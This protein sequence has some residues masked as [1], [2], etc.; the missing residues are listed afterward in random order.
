MTPSLSNI[1]IQDR[2]IWITGTSRG[3]GKVLA[4]QFIN[5]G[6]IV[7]ATCRSGKQEELESLIAEKGSKSTVLPQDVTK[8][9]DAENISKYIRS[10]YGRLDVLINNAA[11]DP[12]VPAE[13]MNFKDWHE[14]INTNLDGSWLCCQYAIPLMKK[15]SYGKIIQVGSITAHLGMAALAHYEASKMGL[16]GMTRGLA[17]DLGTY[18]IRANCIILGAVEVEKE[19]NQFK[20]DELLN[21]INQNQCIP[22]RI[23]P[24][25][26]EPT[27][28]FLSSSASD[29]ITGQCLTIDQ[30]WTHS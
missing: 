1:D 8:E 12:R 18:G 6:A 23:L 2:V 16:I 27:F 25:D 10:N 7:I 3:I 30:G 17:R 4:K 29:S 21:I 26:V 11:I 13:K 28:S 9:S 20:K 15:H 5:R 22:G 14:V 24:E 19:A